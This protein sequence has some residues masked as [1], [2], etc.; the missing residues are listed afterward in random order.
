MILTE[1]LH[2]KSKMHSTTTRLFILKKTFTPEYNP[3][4]DIRIE[5]RIRNGIGIGMGIEKNILEVNAS[6]NCNSVLISWVN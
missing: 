2:P 1:G 4:I 6:W 5:N 3:I